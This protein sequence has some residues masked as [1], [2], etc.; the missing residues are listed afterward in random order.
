MHAASDSG[1]LRFLSKPKDVTVVSGGTAR[2][3]C[4]ATG[5][6]YPCQVEWLHNGTRVVEIVNRIGKK[7]LKLVIKGIDQS[8]SGVYECR[9]HNTNGTIRTSAIVT[10]NGK[11]FTNNNNKVRCV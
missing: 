4:A 3:Q 8:K 5:D 10:V 6:P 2:L 9:V 11:S 7:R 1:Q